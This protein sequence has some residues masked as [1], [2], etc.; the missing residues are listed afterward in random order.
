M[1]SDPFADQMKRWWDMDTYASVCDV[2]GRS[3]DEKRS[4][5]ILETTNHNGERH[6]LPNNF[7]SAYQQC[8]SIEKTLSK[9]P[10]LKETYKTT[11]E[12]DLKNNFIRKL[13][14]KENVG[15]ENDMQWF[16]PHHPV[17]HSHNPGK[18]RRVC[19]AASKFRGV[20]LN[21]KLLSG[22]DFCEICLELFPGLE[23]IK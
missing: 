1:S 2:S 18:V 23:N 6:Y 15:T 13:K 5:A 21:N 20:S 10:E 8:L 14:H 11:I 17:K 3:K 4:Y 7:Y 9:D 19:N 16:L 22:P 12:K